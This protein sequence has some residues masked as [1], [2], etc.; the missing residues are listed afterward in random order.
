MIRRIWADNFKSLRNFE[1]E[2]RPF[3]VLVGANAS[4]KSNVLDVLRFIRDAIDLGSGVSG[5]LLARGGWRGVVS[6]PQA[7][8]FHLGI[9]ADVFWDWSSEALWFGP[10][11]PTQ[12]KP[13]TFE[14][15]FEISSQNGEVEVRKERLGQRN[16]EIWTPSVERAENHQICY[17]SDAFVNVEG[18]TLFSW[19]IV[20]HQLMLNYLSGP[21]GEDLHHCIAAWQFL[22]MHPGKA[23][24]PALTE[25]SPILSESGDNLARVLQV[26]DDSARTQVRSALVR[27]V[28]GFRDF[29]TE[30]A[31]GR[32]F[33]TIDEDHSLKLL[34]ESVSDGTLRL[35]AI[36]AVYY[37]AHRPP[38]L[39]IDEP[40]D[41][42]H[43]E[44]IETVIEYLRAMSTETQV[45]I[46]THSPTL[47]DQCRPEEV[48]LLDKIGGGTRVRRVDDQS[49]IHEFLKDWT[50]GELWT[51]DLLPTREVTSG[52]GVGGAG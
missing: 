8:S 51:R 21:P 25:G 18:I 15:E 39:C 20:E 43:P 36:Y 50:L 23:R 35:L 13:S 5:A 41:G 16:R 12:D 28:P 46:T 29:G 27:D 14:Y 34:P 2:L 32:V 7:L 48:V 33:L 26:L 9:S 19:P 37:G 17:H 6:D 22:Q 52:T 30:V 38:L 45:I 42:L 47:V 3:N 31:G 11:V 44:L 49:Q 1:L 24:Q 4:G 40:E 10:Q